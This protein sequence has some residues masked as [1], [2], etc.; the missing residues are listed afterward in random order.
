[1]TPW[2]SL[3]AWR[4]QRLQHRVPAAGVPDHVPVTHAN[5]FGNCQNRDSV[6]VSAAAEFYGASSGYGISIYD[7]SVGGWVQE[8]GTS[9]ASPMVAAIFTR[10]G[11]ATATS[12]DLGFI[13]T[14]SRPSTTSPQGTNAIGNSCT[15]A[16]LRGGRRLGRTHGRGHAQRRQARPGRHAQH[17]TGSSSGGGPTAVA[18]T[19]APSTTGQRL[20]LGRPGRLRLGRSEAAAGARVRRRHRLGRQLEQVGVRVHHGRLHGLAFDALGLLAMGAGALAI[21]RRR[22]SR[23]GRPSSSIR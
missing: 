8:M 3:E 14:T 6:D 5:A 17:A 1:M 22:R 12:N 15:D 19:A 11:V 9:A 4:G 10:V 7:T 16:Q 18:S 21:A 20:R 13:Y 2:C 23:S